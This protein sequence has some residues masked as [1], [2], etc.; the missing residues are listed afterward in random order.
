MTARTVGRR[1]ENVRE[2]DGEDLLLAQ[3]EMQVA[4]MLYTL[5]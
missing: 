5:L 3:V 1:R 2:D 4:R